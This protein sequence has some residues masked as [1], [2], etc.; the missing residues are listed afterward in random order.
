[1]ADFILPNLGENVPQGD[2]LQVLVKPGDRLAK[3][4]PVLELE[5]DKATLEVPSN[6]EGVVKDVRVKVGDKVKTGQVIL[7][8]DGASEAASASDRKAASP[9]TEKAPA[10]EKAEKAEK[11]GASIPA[12]KQEEGEEEAEK[13]GDK[14]AEPT[15]KE[16][17]R[18]RAPVV[19]FRGR[20]APA[21]APAAAA[22]IPAVP[23]TASAPA[24]PSVRRVAREIGVDITQVTGSGPNGRI[25]EEDVKTFARQIL[26]SLGGG[27]L[28]PTPASR[29]GSVQLP[30]FSKWGEVERKNMTGVRRKTAE[31]L[32]HAWSQIPHVTQFDKADMTVL[33]EIRPKYAA[34]AERAGGKLTVTAVLTK[35]VATALKKFPQFNS[36]IDMATESII[37]KKYVHVGIAVDTE[38]GLLVPVVRNADQKNILQIAVEIHQLAEKAK[39]RKLSLDEMTGGSMS[40]T[41]LGGIGGTAFTPIVNWPEVAI[42]GVSRGAQ[43]PVYKNG[44][45]E[46]RQMLPLS[47]SYDHRVI[48]GADAIR[49]LRWVVEAIEQPFTVMLRG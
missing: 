9:S 26:S 14:P 34:E 18:K 39:A 20:Q 35:I 37:Y 12:Q 41:N 32:S 10:P 6:V 38:H 31:H 23:S 25:T 17:A 11:A 33:E 36:S 49:F 16:D 8:V 44:V 48:D 21:A 7:T 4:Q 2:V 43:E 45:I 5:T 19:D 28:A 24:A 1:M 42:L 29:P 22:T 15:A 27:A 40:I 13:E 46:P 47:L 3:D 30:D